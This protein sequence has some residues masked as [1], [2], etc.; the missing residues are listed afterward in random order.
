MA[1]TPDG[2]GY[3]ILTGDG[4][5][6]TFGDATFAGAIAGGDK[7]GSAIVSMAATPDG[8]GYWILTGDGRIFTF[9]D[10][11]FAGATTGAQLPAPVVAIARTPDGKGYWVLASDGSILT[12]GDAVGHGS[13]AG[14]TSAPAVG[15]S[16]SPAGGGY[17]VV[18]GSRPSVLPFNADALAYLA[19]RGG[20]VTAAV[21]DEVSGNTYL[22]H[23]GLGNHTAS[24]VKV[25]IMATLFAEVDAA[26]RALTGTELALLGQMIDF[27]NN[28]AASSLW[29]EVGAGPA[30]ASF[31]TNIPM[32]ATSMGPDG[33]WGFTVTTALDQINLL[34][35]FDAPNHVLTDADRSRGLALMESVTPSQRWGIPAGVPAGV[36]V[37]NKNGWSP[38]SGHG[39]SINS[40][41]I[42]QGLGRHYV[43]AV[44]TGDDPSMGY[45]ISTIEGLATRVWANPAGA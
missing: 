32:P 35:A 24:I 29:R 11:M 3:W 5:I 16:T 8:K 42:V 43:I 15:L 36:T 25:D 20:A 28:A 30:V 44:L 40:I 26:K 33:L 23:P 37:A 41:G 17:W 27:S 21:F 6:F 31:N 1:A 4:R 18:Y 34:R 13:L 7:L 9:G 19:T 2:K 12:F 39:W 14:P 22:Y 38:I 45:G 10:A